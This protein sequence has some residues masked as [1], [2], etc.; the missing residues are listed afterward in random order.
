MSVEVHIAPESGIGSLIVRRP[1]RRNA[2]DQDTMRRF[3]MAL[4]QLTMD[5]V[6]RV[7]VVGGAAPAFISGGDLAELRYRTSPED[8]HALA[9][10]GTELCDAIEALPFPVLAAIDGPAVGGGAEVAM[11]CDL[12]FFGPRG[13]I[14]F[15]H[16]ALGV[17]TAWGTL[18]RLTAVCPAGTAALVYS[19]RTCHAE[20]AR[21]LG[22]GEPVD[23]AD[24][25]GW[26]QALRAATE[27]I[28]QPRGALAR[29]KRSLVAARR[30]EDLRRVEREQFVAGW[31]SQEHID[32]V[33]SF[34]RQRSERQG[35]ASS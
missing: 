18:A 10:A 2:L 26:D 13:A 25:S 15:R 12:R 22:L 28:R 27:I 31:T 14:S 19:A 9:D 32:A 34:F 11:A 17:T 20:E 1:E 23:A 4:R 5:P 3:A 21:A 24:S 29:A 16:V 7:L 30:R 33:E 8:A 6:C 35:D